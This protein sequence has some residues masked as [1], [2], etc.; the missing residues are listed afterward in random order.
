MVPGSNPGGPNFFANPELPIANLLRL[1]GRCFRVAVEIAVLSALIL[2]T[3]CANYENVFVGGQV[4]FVDADCYARMTRARMV[5]Q[6]PGLIVREHDFE[7]YPEGVTPHTTAPFDYL[8]VVL[9]WALSAFTAQPLDLAGAFVSPLLALAG[10]WFLWGWSRRFAGPGRYA[11]LLLYALSAILVHGTALGRPDH[12]SLLI[13]AL[14]VALAAEW[15][16][17]E[18]PSRGWSVVSGLSWGLALWVSLYEPLILLGG[19]A[20]F[21]AD[22][23]SK[24]TAPSRRVGWA[25]LLGVVLLAALVERRW[26]EWPGVQPFFANWSG[27]IGEL[28]SVS[29]TNRIWLDWCSGLIFLSPFLLVAARRRRILPSAFAALLLLTF[30]LTLWEAR[31]GYFLA[32]V[33]V[34]TLPVQIAVV[35]RGWLTWGALALVLLPL[36][37][38]WDGQF[39]PNEQAAIGRLQDRSEA[40][41]W[42][43]AASR[44][45]DLPR[46]PVLAPWWLSPAT[47]YWSGQPTVAGSS[48]ESLPGIAASARFFLATSPAEAEAILRRHHVR[49]VLVADGDRVAENSAA[50]LRV[51]APARALCRLLDRSPSQAP[52]F[53]ALQW[54]NGACKVYQVRN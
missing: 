40:V 44:L 1:S 5:A 7:N 23:W 42:R 25:V 16:L 3:R 13:V 34:L 54:Q 39:W 35:R 52:P 30:C 47:G 19:L 11:A 43:A 51:T 48:H 18:Q 2:G 8:I 32:V 21:S 22:R 36:L 38:F 31:W 29:L 33:F 53:L 14:L 15:T 26:P 49:W 41:Q 17:Q 50:I 12:Q 45:R 9:A 37:Q 4:Y 6:H 46:A 28:R 24:L 27:T 10:G 20:L